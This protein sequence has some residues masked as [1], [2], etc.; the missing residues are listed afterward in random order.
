M[1]IFKTYLFIAGFFIAGILLSACNKTDDNDNQPISALTVINAFS[2]VASID[3]FLDNNRVNTNAWEYK[4]SSGYF[5]IYPGIRN[6]KITNGLS[7][8]Q[9][10]V[11]ANYDFP[12]GRY[13]SLFIAPKLETNADSAI[14]VVAVD[15]L[16]QPEAGKA[17][18]RFVNLTPG[19]RK[20]DLL[21]KGSTD[22]LFSNKAFK[23]VTGFTS[24][25]PSSNFILQIRENGTDGSIKLELPSFELK[26]GKIYTVYSNGLWNGTGSSAFGANVTINYN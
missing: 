19:T 11:R 18:L 21:V 9:T 12:A 17:S 22:A 8:N 10:L 23:E 13:I 1:R 4:V 25:S 3:F 2:G 26:A 20:L 15:S 6:V 14:F 16:V 24:V 7:S 5:N